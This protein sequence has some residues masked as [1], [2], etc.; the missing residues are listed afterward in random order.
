MR[1]RELDGEEEEGGRFQYRPMHRSD[2]HY[3]RKRADAITSLA[4]LEFF[5]PRESSMNASANAFRQ[6]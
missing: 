3:H 2:A 5:F 1:D 4:T 6:C